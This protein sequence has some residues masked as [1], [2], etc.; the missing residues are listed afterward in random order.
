MVV[1]K[2]SKGQ[3][4]AIIESGSSKNEQL[5]DTVASLRQNKNRLLK[6]KRRSSQKPT[7]ALKSSVTL[8]PV[9][10]SNDQDLKPYWNAAC[11]AMQSRLWSLPETGLPDQVYPSSAGQS[12][13]TGAPLRSWKKVIA[14]KSS[15]QPSLSVSLPAS[16]PATTENDLPVVKVVA[17]KVRVIPQCSQQWASLVGL[18]RVAY[19][20]AVEKIKAALESKQN[21]NQVALRREIR[22]ELRE[23]WTTYDSPFIS[24]VVDEEVNLAFDAFKKCAAKWRKGQKAQLRFRS[25]RAVR[26]GFTVQK[27]SKGGQLYPRVLGYTHLTEEI[28][29]EKQQVRVIQEHG[30]Y[31]AIF[32][33]TLTLSENQADGEVVA[34]DPGVRTFITSFSEKDCVKYG[35]G[36]IKKLHGLL[37]KQDHW[38]SIRAKLPRLTRAS[39]QWVRDRHRQCQKKLDRLYWRIKNLVDD[40]HRRVA[41]DLVSRYKVILLP[42]FETSQMV[43]RKGRKIRKK[44]ARQMLRL[45]FF[46]FSLH[47]AWMCQ[48][49]GRTLLRVN[50]AY[51]S[52]TDS[53]TGEIKTIGSAKSINGLDRDINGARGILLR[54]LTR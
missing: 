4:A 32:R 28:N 44:T 52:K 1:S 8:D 50:E 13:S 54:A 2:R 20:L 37:Q 47:L 38:I 5:S 49:Y 10:I 36:F 46:R 39:R 30:R 11:V 48:K 12:S 33:Q 24:T 45:G 31:F 19:N 41:Y 3:K 21:L 22:D 15:T 43:E 53:R 26:Q 6:R 29:D 23:R 42:T 34:L 27:S 35:D 14:K 51:T 25:R 9:S 16:S 17:K 18:A 40:L 7:Q